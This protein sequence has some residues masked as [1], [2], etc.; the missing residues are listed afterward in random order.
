MKT[1][2]A[3]RVLASALAFACLLI[4]PAAAQANPFD[5][6]LAPIEVGATMPPT[7]FVDQRGAHF[8]FQ[9]ARGQTTVVGFIYTRCADDCPVITQKFGV[10]NRLLGP[11]PYQLVEISIDPSHDTLP[12]VQAYARK[13][14]ATSSRW[15]ILTGSPQR[16][17][18]FVRSSGV[19]VIDNGT[20]KLIHNARL[21]I[22]D[23]Q[24]RLA[25]VDELVAW[26]PATVV[27]EV[28]H[29]AGK[30]SSLLGRADFALTSA[31]AQFCGGSYKTASGILDVLASVLLV[32][33]GIFILAWIQRRI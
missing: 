19:S 9:D 30:S 4:R 26:D 24:G 16:V 20:D 18:N 25:D 17:E 33:S 15:R 12:V 8:S 28:R 7:T 10:L 1:I 6:Q 27:A 14:G 29:V 13:F 32:G 22:V 31:V 2:A 21:L 3:P 11:G 5:V 23:P